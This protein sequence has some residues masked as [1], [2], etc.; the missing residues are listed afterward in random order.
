[1]RGLGGRAPEARRRSQRPSPRSRLS[2]PQSLPCCST[3]RL[4]RPSAECRDTQRPLASI[5]A[6]LYSHSAFR[7]TSSI[8]PAQGVTI[9]DG[10]LQAG[11]RQR[12]WNPLSTLWRLTIATPAIAAR[13]RVE[14][15]TRL[16]PGFLRSR[17][18]RPRQRTI[19][20]Q[21]LSP[22]GRHCP[23]GD[24]DACHR[25]RARRRAPA[26]GRGEAILALPLISH[27]RRCTV[28]FT[29]PSA[30]PPAQGNGLVDTASR[31][32]VDNAHC[33]GQRVRIVDLSEA[34]ES[35]RF[36]SPCRAS[37]EALA[38]QRN[39]GTARFSP[40]LLRTQEVYERKPAQGS[41]GRAPKAEQS[42]FRRPCGL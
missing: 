33:S 17:G 16:S 3:N 4:F 39:C 24:R 30:R 23:P 11:F 34:K 6:R 21:A 20:R 14:T 28:T 27:V 35:R 1:M 19:F 2:R 32:S 13:V 31:R 9:P 15:L 8:P 7:H 10:N 36:L 26:V 40:S 5:A 12:G 37:V 41:P 18:S 38:R 25:V 29:L 22:R 42:R